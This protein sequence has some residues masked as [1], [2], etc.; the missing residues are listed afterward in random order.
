MRLT[1]PMF[2]LLLL[3]PSLAQA[4]NVYIEVE[5]QM[6]GTSLECEIDDPLAVEVSAD[7]WLIEVDENDT[8]YFQ[9][10]DFTAGASSYTVSAETSYA[11]GNIAWSK[12]GSTATSPGD[13]PEVE[14]DFVVFAANNSG[15]SMLRRGGHYHVKTAGG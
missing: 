13:S 6:N 10:S 2:A 8:V 15:G 11:S 5:C 14:A 12:S 9:V 7:N 3:T 1:L 4:A